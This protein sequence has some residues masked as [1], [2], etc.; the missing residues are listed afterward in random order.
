MYTSVKWKGN[1]SVFHSVALFTQFWGNRPLRE[2]NIR[3][4]LMIISGILRTRCQSSELLA[5]CRQVELEIG[6]EIDDDRSFPDF[7]N[8]VQMK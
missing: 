7:E 4:S 1:H 8:S 5:D 2:T 3:V 6:Q